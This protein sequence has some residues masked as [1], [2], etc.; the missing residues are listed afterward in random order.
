[1]HCAALWQGL[2]LDW[3]VAVVLL[4]DLDKEI[5]REGELG[6]ARGQ[7]GP[8]GVGVGGWV[9]R[10][11]GSWGCWLQKRWRMLKGRLL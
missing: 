3:E 1:M 11:A 7:V 10:V 6:V 2:D 8:G 5:P 4:H 9:G